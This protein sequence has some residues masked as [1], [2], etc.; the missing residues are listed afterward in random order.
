MLDTP[1]NIKHAAKPST[2]AFHGCLY[3]KLLTQIHISLSAHSH[4]LQLA[5][6]KTSVAN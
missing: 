5:T 2:M 3:D 6:L 4:T 1:A